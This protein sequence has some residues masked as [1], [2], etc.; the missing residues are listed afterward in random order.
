VIHP[1]RFGV[2]VVLPFQPVSVRS[3]PPI[4]HTTTLY[5]FVEIRRVKI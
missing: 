1:R 2:L 3:R 4:V 5:G